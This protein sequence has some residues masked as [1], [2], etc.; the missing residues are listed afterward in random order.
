M[1]FITYSLTGHDLEPATIFPA[2]QFFS[3]ISGAISHIPPQL[4]NM[5]DAR[6]AVGECSGT[7]MSD[8][9]IFRPRERSTGGET[10][11]HSIS[12]QSAN[13]NRPRS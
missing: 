11:C 12:A 2:L 10:V 1:T 9:L 5:L 3:V 7:C 4:S 8:L 13:S 6:V